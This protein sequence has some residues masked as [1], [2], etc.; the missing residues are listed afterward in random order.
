ME[1]ANSLPLHQVREA[2]S[3]TAIIHAKPSLR[4]P[5]VRA[6]HLQRTKTEVPCPAVST[7]CHEVY[8]QL[9]QCQAG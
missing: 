1:E 6:A 7:G 9:H 8:V 2:A 4:N 3:K 5:A